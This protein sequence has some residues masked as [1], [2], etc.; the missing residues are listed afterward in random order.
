MARKSKARAAAAAVR[1]NEKMQAP[2]QST[3]TIAGDSIARQLGLRSPTA[4]YSAVG[5][6]TTKARRQRRAGRSFVGGL[7]EYAAHKAGK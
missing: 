1:H 2:R 3:L 5:K 4:A 7:A 6:E